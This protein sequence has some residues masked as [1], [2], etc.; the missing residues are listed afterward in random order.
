[1]YSQLL[2]ATDASPASLSMTR[3]VTVPAARTADG[4]A[5]EAGCRKG[6]RH[7][8]RSDEPSCRCAHSRPTLLTPRVRYE[9][10]STPDAGMTRNA[11]GRYRASG[12]R[13]LRPTLHP[14]CVATVSL[15]GDT[16]AW[17]EPCRPRSTTGQASVSASPPS[18]AGGAATRSMTWLAST[19]V[20]RPSRSFQRVS[21]RMSS[22]SP[23]RCRTAT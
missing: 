3:A 6:Q 22:V 8:Q 23:V 5:G 15:A 18:S 10:T 11:G 21:I 19:I 4:A 14:G 9:R 1:M 2:P 12:R 7:Q 20:G 16:V 13:V 17:H